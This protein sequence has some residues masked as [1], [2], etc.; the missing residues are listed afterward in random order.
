MSSKTERRSRSFGGTGGRLMIGVAAAALVALAPSSAQAQLDGAIVF[1]QSA[2]SGALQ[3]GRLTLRW[4]A[5]GRSPTAS[6]TR[7][8]RSATPR[9]RP[10]RCGA[11]ATPAL[12][13]VSAVPHT[14]YDATL[15]ALAVALVRG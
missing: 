3:G 12:P 14:D 8:P 10:L 1:M 7:L 13:C 5:G 6:S 4:T 9:R 11:T 2:R 15:E